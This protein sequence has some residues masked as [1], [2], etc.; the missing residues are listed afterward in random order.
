M[1]HVVNGARWILRGRGATAAT[2][3]TVLA[4]F[5]ILFINVGTGILTARLLKPQGRGELSALAIWPQSLAYVMTLGLPSALRY[6]LKRHPE[7]KSELFSAAVLMSTVLGAVAIVIGVVFIPQFISQY[8]ASVIHFAQ[9]FML[10]S[11]LLL[12]S[13]TFVAALE[14]SEEFTFANQIRYLQPLITLIALGTFALTQR[15]TPF[16]AA[17]AYIFLPSLPL[18]LWML[19]HLWKSFHPQWYGLGAAYKWLTSYSLRASGIDLLGT[20]ADRFDQV[21][22]VNLLPPASMG[23][24][25]VALS[26]SRMLNLF[27][28]STITVLLPKIAARPLKEVIALTG[29]AVRISTAFTT[30]IAVAVMIP[31]PALLQLLY[32][33]E[34]LEAVSVFRIL[35]VEAVLSGEAL[36]LAQAFLALGR[37]GMLTLV[38]GVGLGLTIALMLVLIPIL[39]LEGAGL[40]L[41]C[42]TIV[43]LFFVILCF[44]LIL[45]VPPPNLIVTGED[46]QVIKQLIQQVLSQKN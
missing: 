6:H 15:L 44:P 38:Q 43:R 42:S 16:T 12:L 1:K 29:Q 10:L 20:L 18:F 8:S 28:T 31:I 21:I 5:L 46:L 2:L 4:R 40:A 32:G 37:P 9:W 13:E 22:V 24:Y 3:Q 33:V 7:Q 26:M 19:I 34:Y 11:P 35:V 17:L 25:A 41:L 30:I 39:G 23:L 36:V 27:Q 45:K 14:A